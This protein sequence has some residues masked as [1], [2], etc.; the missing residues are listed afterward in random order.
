MEMYFVLIRKGSSFRNLNTKTENAFFYKDSLGNGKSA[1]VKPKVD[2]L[3][4]ADFS[5]V[6]VESDFEGGISA[7][8]KYLT[9]NLD[10]PDRA[11]KLQKQGMVVVQFVVDK[12]GAIF[13]PRISR[14]VEY[15]LDEEALR[16]IR[17]APRWIPAIQDGRKVKSYK[18][19]PIIFKLQ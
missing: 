5:K 11:M 15:S 12:E 1:E 7:W 3:K 17:K 9:K 8:G 10:Y 4:G 13:D 14:S 16:I 18:R 2:S 6:E 19:Q